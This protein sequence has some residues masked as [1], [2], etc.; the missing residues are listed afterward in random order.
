MKVVNVRAVALLCSLIGASLP[1]VA[2]E[3]YPNRPIRMIVSYPPGGVVD[4]VAR[5]LGAMMQE[6]LGQS[7]VIDNRPGGATIIATELAAKSK[8]DGYT[9]YMATDGP[10][11]INPF[12]YDK[13]PYDP[14]ADFMPI[15]MVADAPLALVTNTAQKGNT[16]AEFIAYAKASPKPL[17]YASIGTG[18]SQHLA[19]EQ[20]RT[21]A[22]V[23]MNHIPYKGGALALNDVLSGQIEG[24]FVALSTAIPHVKSGKLKMLAVGTAK[25]S[26]LAPDVPTVAESG[27][28]GFEQTPWMAIVVPTGTPKAITER[29]EKE[30]QQVVRSPAFAEKVIA[31]GNIPVLG[32]AEDLRA[33]IQSQ[34][35]KY[36]P[37]IRALNIRPQ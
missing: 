20:L 23:A 29:L 19:M 22:G 5:T 24:I 35:R 16:L 33:L 7:M 27:Y 13:L 9:W 4:L 6:S 21:A 18:S 25:R 34:Q 11:V 31:T 14:V 10:F 17:N 30:V 26:I 1:S 12:M 15:S 8:P 2:Q 32:T 37:L 3:A 36:G 28:P